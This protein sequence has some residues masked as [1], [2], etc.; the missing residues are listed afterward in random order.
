MLKL[1]YPDTYYNKNIFG[2]G[3][4]GVAKWRTS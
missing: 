1:I 4:T 2:R 3:H